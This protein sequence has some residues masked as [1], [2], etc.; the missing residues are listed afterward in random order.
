[1]IVLDLFKKGEE[2]SLKKVAKTK[3]EIIFVLATL[4]N[5]YLRFFGSFQLNDESNSVR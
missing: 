1:M 4:L 5:E 3:I 2:L